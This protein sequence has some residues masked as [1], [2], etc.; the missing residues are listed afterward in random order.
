MPAVS[1]RLVRTTLTKF[2]LQVVQCKH[3]F[4]YSFNEPHPSPGFEIELLVS[5]ANNRVSFYFDGTGFYRKSPRYELI[6][7]IGRYININYYFYNNYEG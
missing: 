5:L 3:V 7:I 2:M 1:N 6:I 4:N